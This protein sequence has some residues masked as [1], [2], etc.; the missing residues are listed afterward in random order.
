MSFVCDAV[1]ARQTVCMCVDKNEKAGHTG[2]GHSVEDMSV[3]P[4]L[5]HT[6]HRG[7]WH[8]G[9]VATFADVHQVTALDLVSTQ[10]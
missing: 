7:D 2:L 1:R 5:L 8:R 10:L 6:G 4:E 9:L 3:D